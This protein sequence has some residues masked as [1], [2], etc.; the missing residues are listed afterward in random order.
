MDGYL[1]PDACRPSPAIQAEKELVGD[2]CEWPGD[3]GGGGGGG[4][5]SVTDGQNGAVFLTCSCRDTCSKQ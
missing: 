2:E 3:G 1:R 5:L 4:L